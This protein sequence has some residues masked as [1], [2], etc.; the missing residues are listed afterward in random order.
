MIAHLRLLILLVVSILVASMTGCA[1]PNSIT[2]QELERIDTFVRNEIA[3]QDIP[4]AA[5]AVV[6]NGEVIYSA[7]YGVRDKSSEEPVTT[8]SVFHTASVSKT[9]VATAIVQLME[10]GQID[11]D[12]KVTSYLPY[13]ELADP[14]HRNITIRQILSHTSG[15]PDVI[16]YEWDN[17]QYEDGAAE[18][19]VRSLK[20]EKLIF[21]PGERAKYSNM[22]FNVLGDLIAKVSGL[23]FEEYVAVNI[24]QPIGMLD[25]SFNYTKIDKE[26]TVTGHVGIPA[27]N[28]E[29]YPYNRQHAPSSTLN[30]NVED[31]SK[32]M[33][34]NLNRGELN[35]VRIL[36][37][38]SYDLLW[39]RTPPS[40]AVGLSWFLS[41][42]NGEATA[43]HSGGDTGFLSYVNLFPEKDIGIVALVNWDQGSARDLALGVADIL[44]PEN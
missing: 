17:P 8:R 43:Y 7:A 5:I 42:Y 34:V 21:A 16:D 1:Q 25:S 30:S 3:F 18:Q 35:G 29:V 20:A 39:T 36:E 12:E 33:L 6:H 41:T 40:R 37:S 26:L 28:S 27:V 32:W 44:V 11:L 15:M 38:I 22:A 10:K 4:G 24:L 19:Y 31:L 13:F 14:R 23:S 2:N 9:F